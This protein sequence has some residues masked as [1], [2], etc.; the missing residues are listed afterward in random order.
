[1]LT[2]FE[3][4]AKKTLI[5]TDG[6]NENVEKSSRNMSKVKALSNNCLNVFD[7]LHNEK[8][9]LTKEAIAKIEEVLA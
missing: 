3:A 5:I 8:V 7:I 6:I 4:A 2:G 1:M 9:L